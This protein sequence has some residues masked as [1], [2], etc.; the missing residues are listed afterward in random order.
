M[1]IASLILGIIGFFLT[2][3][4]IGIIPST[5]G[6]IL[7]I[8]ALATKRPKK[9][10][11]IAGI[12]TSGLGIFLFV[13]VF[14]VALGAAMQTE[15]TTDKIMEE[16]YFEREPVEESTVVENV[17]LEDIGIEEKE[18]YN[19]NG[20]SI[21]AKAMEKNGSSINFIFVVSN[22]S[23][24]D[25]SISAHSFDVNGIMIGTNLY[26]FG[27]VD[28]PAKKKAKL[29]I[30]LDSRDLESLGINEIYEL[31]VI[32]WAYADSFKQWNT[33]KLS[34]KTNYY[35]ENFCYTP[36]G[37][38]IYNDDIMTVWRDIEST[39]YIIYNKSQYNARYTVENCSVNGWSYEITNYSY[40]LYDEEIH[41][42]SY[43]VF[44]LDIN[45]DFLRENDI[46]SI[47]NVEFDV[48]LRDGYW[49][50]SGQLWEH[51][52]SKINSN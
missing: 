2:F 37:E 13:V 29:F 11:A 20:V 26:G 51:K 36:T 46:D 45:D 52:S 15:E 22:E 25:Y 6:L 28:V 34:V 41:S 23:D 39:K 24:M 42:K 40:D 31:N 19:E 12:A 4:V 50:Y 9:K 3:F 30:E 16:M 27:S 7:G 8:V 35:S 21:V 49:N 14:S 47:E 44:E 32:F 18:I 43:A 1:E 48:L 33:D 17:D 10:I 5:I 38:V